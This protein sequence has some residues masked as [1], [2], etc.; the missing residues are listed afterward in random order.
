LSAPEPVWTISR[1]QKFYIELLL[2]NVIDIF[3]V[4][5]GM[6]WGPKAWIPGKWLGMGVKSADSG[7]MA[8]NDG[9]KR[10]FWADGLE[11]GSKAWIP[12]KW[13]GMG[14]KSVDSGQI[15]ASIWLV[16]TDFSEVFSVSVFNLKYNIVWRNLSGSGSSV[17][18]ATGY[19]LDGPGIESRWGCDFSHTSRPA[20]GL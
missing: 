19:G 5:Y 15:T 16:V 11:W 10:G 2:S 8:W 14:V 4:V 7:Q 18:I 13:L 20:L 3:S 6:D 12:G 17:G 9:Q 1:R